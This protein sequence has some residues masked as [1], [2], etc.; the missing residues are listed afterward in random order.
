MS[1]RKI[2]RRISNLMYA[3]LYRKPVRLSDELRFWNNIAPVGR[4]FGSP[5]FERLLKTSTNG[6]VSP[7]TKSTPL[8]PFRSRSACLARRGSA[9][10]KS[11]PSSQLHVEMT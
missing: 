4:E 9:L 8:L 3:R 10:V 5:D 7:R 2:K 6:Q 1:V 11:S